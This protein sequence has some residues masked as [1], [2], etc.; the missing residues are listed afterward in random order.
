MCKVVSYGI[1]E[2]EW[3]YEMSDSQ[4]NTHILE[5][6]DSESDLGIKFHENLK[7]DEHI[8]STVNKVNRFIGL[9]R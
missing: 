6:V 5:T 7:F 3:E 9:I 8:D 4:N 1:V 2:V